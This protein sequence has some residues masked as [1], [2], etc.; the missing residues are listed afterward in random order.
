[1]SE[2][3]H[4]HMYAANVMV[5]LGRVGRR[6]SLWAFWPKDGLGGDGMTI[7]GVQVPRGLRVQ[8]GGHGACSPK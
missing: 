6:L 3:P 5:K 7:F 2:N 4:T 1:M 8:E